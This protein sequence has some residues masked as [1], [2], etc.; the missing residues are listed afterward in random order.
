MRRASLTTVDAPKNG[1]RT[2]RRVAPYLWPEGEGWVK[3]R[4]IFALVALFLSKLIAVGTPLFYKAAVDALAGEG[5]SA[6]WMLGLGAIGLTVAY[7]MARL[8]V[9]GFQQARDAIRFRNADE[10][11]ALTVERRV[12]HP[13]AA[14]ITE[15]A[16]RTLAEG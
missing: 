14:M 16:R 15:R 9:V 2:I 1:W 11:F 13:V 8:M 4:V 7:G 12:T 3:R 5:V 10:F 6:A